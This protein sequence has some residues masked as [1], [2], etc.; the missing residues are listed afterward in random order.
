MTH[1]LNR[2]VVGT[3]SSLSRILSLCTAIMG[4]TL[5]IFS[6]KTPKTT[7]Q[8]GDG[9]SVLTFRSFGKGKPVFIL[10][11][12]P[13]HASFY[14][15]SVAKRISQMGYRAI[16]INQYGTDASVQRFDTARVTLPHFVED[17]E[18]LRKALGYASFTL[19]GHSWGG[20]LAM[21]YVRTYPRTTNGLILS[22][23]GAF[24]LEASDRMAKNIT[25]RLSEADK[26]AM[27]RW[28][29]S[30]EADVDQNRVMLAQRRIRQVAFTYDRANHQRLINEIVNTSPFF[31]QVGNRMFADAFVLHDYQV[32]SHLKDYPSPVLVL[33][34]KQDVLG[35]E[36]IQLIV[37][38]FSNAQLVLIDQ[39]GHYP[40][41]DNPVPYF[42]QIES[43]LR[44]KH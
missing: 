9:D 35:I 24:G 34:G 14:M 16:V 12:G 31:I 7:L 4:V 8:N 32:L 42:N 19:L 43:F 17:I 25:A 11:G 10:S 1:V 3:K 27:K 2:F 36:T 22:C 18:R 33:D 15:D 23:S 28:D 29:D 26:A 6:C 37:S 40:W 30:L 38:S 41:I 39:C 44:K 20:S 21:A 13:G 5:L